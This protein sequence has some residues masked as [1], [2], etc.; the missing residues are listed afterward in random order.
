MTFYLI[1]SWISLEDAKKII[2]E[3]KEE[4]I[5]PLQ[6]STPQITTDMLG[7]DAFPNILG[8]FYYIQICI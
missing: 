8:S 6:I 4:Y 1:C 3:N 7:E 5:I 2:A